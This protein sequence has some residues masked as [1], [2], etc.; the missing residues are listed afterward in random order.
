MKTLMIDLGHGGTDS[1]AVSQ[2]YFEKDIVLL[3]GRRVKELLKDYKPD[4][5]RTTD[6]TLSNTTRINLIKNRYK[7]CISIHVNSGGGNGVEAI[8]SI[9]S[10]KGKEL[11]TKL[12]NNI[13]KET[14][15]PLRKTPVY[16]RTLSNGN[17][18][19]FMN[20]ETG[21][22]I[23]VIVECFFIDSEDI[24]LMNIESIARG[25]SKG[26]IDFI[27]KEIEP[28]G[29]VKLLT[30]NRPLVRGTKGKDVRELQEALV[31]L[32]YDPKGI[33]GH[34][35]NGC[36]KAVREFQRKNG[37]SVDGSVGPAT[38]N[39]INELLLGKPIQKKSKYYKLGDTHIIETTPDN[40]SIEF[41][42]N[43]LRNAGKYG[44][45]GTFYDTPRPHLRDSCWAIAIMN[46]KPIGGNSMFN[47]YNHSIKR[48]TLIYYQDG[49]IGQRKVNSINE[50]PK[51]HVWAIGGYTIVPYMD[52]KGEKMGSG[53]NYKTAHTYIGYK[54]NKI[55]LI[56][57]PNHMIHE[58]THITSTLNLDGCILLDGGGS[59]QLRHPDGSFH[60]SR[61]VNNAIILK[62]V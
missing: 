28:K 27:S 52:F 50:F 43:N 49:T 56:V 25:I 54:G 5:T 30:Y 61:R 8:H 47:S 40:I 48:G 51:P 15:L 29:E 38:V 20:R 22:T 44:I 18:Y 13:S 2:G 12:V 4:M 37:L 23:T 6:K 39:K 36:D 60:Q 19:Y 55:Y 42:N 21:N 11:A 31:R 34:F 1:G 9:K 24:S 14:G 10:N 46:G 32:G 17:D 7:Y 41:L 53:I 59:S 26:F 45:N 35:G 3:I 33:D 58:I 57:K 62:E 16:S